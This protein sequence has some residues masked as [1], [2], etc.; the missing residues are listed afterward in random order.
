MNSEFYRFEQCDRIFC[1]NSVARDL[2]LFSQNRRRNEEDWFGDNNGF[3]CQVGMGIRVFYTELF[4]QAGYD[5][6]GF[7]E[8]KNNK[9]KSQRSCPVEKRERLPFVVFPDH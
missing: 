1:F 5:Y 7:T 9:H 6:S 8:W 2:L 3:V 4:S